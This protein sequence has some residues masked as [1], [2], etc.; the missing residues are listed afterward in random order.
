MRNAL[1]L[2][3]L[4][5]SL[6]LFSETP[7]IVTGLALQAPGPIITYVNAAFSRMVGY[8][9]EEM[10]GLSPRM[11]QGQATNRRV[12]AGLA[13]RLRAGQACSGVIQNY[14][15]SHERYLCQFEIYPVV[16]G[17]GECVAFAG[18]E[19][20]VLRR[21]GRPSSAHPQRFQPLDANQRLPSEGP[22]DRLIAAPHS[23]TGAD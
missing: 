22:Q 5:E 10:I 11:L 3:R 4:F 15:K 23:G 9:P 16:A 7:I 20:E 21:R 17:T 19:R 18:F 8:T 2:E 13:H 1:P 12:L 6:V 14:R